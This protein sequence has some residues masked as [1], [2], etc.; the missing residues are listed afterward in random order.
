MGM[1]VTTQIDE[2]DYDRLVEAN[3]VPGTRWALVEVD[4]A[5]DIEEDAE[6][7]PVSIV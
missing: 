6:P 7:I 1:I 2:P 3:N 5:G 4:E